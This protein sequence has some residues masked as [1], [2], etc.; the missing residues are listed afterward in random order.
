KKSIEE[1][2]ALADEK[3]YQLKRELTPLALM[4]FV[5][6]A[7]IGAGI[8]ILPGTVAALHAGP[9]VIVSFLLSGLIT[10]AVG[11]A[12]V[13]FAS[14]APVAGSAYTYSYIALG[15]IIAWIVGWDL[16]FEFT[17]ITSTVSV[18][19]SG[20]VVEL[21]KTI[22]IELPTAFTRDL[23]SGGLINV[24]AILGLMFVG[25][26]AQSGIKQSGRANAVFTWTKI[27]AILFFIA[28]GIFHIQPEHYTPFTPYGWQGVLTGAALVFFA[29]TGFDG[30]TT[31]LEEVKRPE[32]SIPIAMILG[33]GLLTTFYV[34]VA[35]VLLGMVPYT[36]LNVP[37]P[38]A[39]ALVQVGL[40]WGGA[41]LSVAV[42]F[43]L[44]ATMLT[45]G[46][47][48]TRILFAMSR[49]GLLPEAL[50]KVDEKRRVPL[51]ATYLVFAAAILMGGFLSIDEL[52]QLANI[53]GLSAFFLTTLSVMIMRRVRPDAPR[54]FRVPALPIV[55]TFGLIGTVALILS[56]PRLTF[57]R[58]AIWLVL[59]LVIYFAYGVRHS[60]LN[61]ST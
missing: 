20:Y 16:L 38:A 46:L 51:V 22:G 13:E 8:F 30:V 42:I 12:Y 40:N 33:L 34:I 26:I 15:E 21:L 18:G 2:R 14:M 9:G 39:Y 56:L 45:N 23:V 47:S 60:R 3:T 24:P 27:G 48:A 28:V 52:A 1:A 10:I 35:I 37:D 58:F 57:L 25:W 49:D 61:R 50:A 36:E 4:L 59:G 43:G 31:V 32:R 6:G 54:T 11:L 55:G 17:V 53:G 7:T 44:V 19:W 29:Y 5:L 41:L